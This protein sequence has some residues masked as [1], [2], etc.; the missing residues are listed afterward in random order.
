MT[1]EERQ[2]HEDEISN[3]YVP[4]L[5]A[6]DGKTMQEIASLPDRKSVV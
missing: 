2:K 3:K 5:L 6:A 4:G 1:R